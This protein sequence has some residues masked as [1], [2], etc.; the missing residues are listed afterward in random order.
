MKL[1][2]I[3]LACMASGGG[4]GAATPAAK[5]KPQPAA[6]ENIADLLDMADQLDKA[7]KAEFQE[8]LDKANLCTA[9]REFT[10]TRELL[11]KAEKLAASGADKKS[12]QGAQRRLEGE[13]EVVAEERREAQREAARE[14]RR[15]ARLERE[16][17][18]R[19]ERQ[20]REEE[21]EADRD[22]ARYARTAPSY[23]QPS[24]P[25]AVLGM[26]VDNYRKNTEALAARQEQQR[27]EQEQQRRERESAQRQQDQQR[28]DRLRLAQAEQNQRERERERQRQAE[29][30]RRA[31]EAREAKRLEEQRLA[32]QERER[33]RREEELARQRE[34]EQEAQAKRSYLAQMRSGIHLQA[35]TCPDGEGNYYIVGI[36]PRPK[37]EAVSCIDVSYEAI[38]EG[39]AVGSSGVASNFL[40][41]ATDCYM[42]DAIKIEPKPA[43]KVKQ[44]RVLV[45]DVKECGG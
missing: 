3:F 18:E 7:D 45:R 20:R 23:N 42:G 29:A 28:A 32:Q 43:C 26:A 16:E 10:C 35:R 1:L 15:L 8:L 37:P 21:E 44:V 11:K 4:A 33:Q 9:R 25:L 22:A 2:W 14:E 34:K 5:T 40:G 13:I 12:L 6:K 19:R 39:S 17:Q 31:Q 30:E 41:A 36:R 38:C 24:N 27:R